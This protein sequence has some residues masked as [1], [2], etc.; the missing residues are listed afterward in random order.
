MTYVLEEQK[1][2]SK[3]AAILKVVSDEYMRKIIVSARS[4]EKSIDEISQEN[5][6]PISTCYRR[7]HE[8]VNMGIL[9]EQRTI[10]TNEGKKYQTYKSALREAMINFSNQGI[11]IETTFLPRDQSN[12][13]E[14]HYRSANVRTPSKSIDEQLASQDSSYSTCFSCERHPNFPEIPPL[15]LHRDGV[16]VVCGNPSIS[17]L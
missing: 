4:V 8:L 11:S 7:V 17:L 2:Q 5:A 13:F 12:H 10:L 3:E 14:W 16:C 9:R 15:T 6:I 1:D